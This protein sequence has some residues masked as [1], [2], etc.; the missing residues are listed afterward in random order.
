MHAEALREA[1]SDGRRL[2]AALQRAEQRLEASQALSCRTIQSL[3]DEL[4]QRTAVAAVGGESPAPLA[5]CASDDG[6]G[7]DGDSALISGAGS[8]GGSADPLR[9][10]SGVPAGAS[11]AH[12]TSLQCGG[13]GGSD[14]LP[15]CSDATAV[16]RAGGRPYGA[17]GGLLQPAWEH[18]AAAER[19]ASALTDCSSSGSGSGNA[20]RS[21]ASSERSDDLVRDTAPTA[22]EPAAA[23]AAMAT[24][25]AAAVARPA[26]VSSKQPLL[27]AALSDERASNAGAASEQQHHLS[28]CKP[29]PLA[30]ERSSDADAASEQQLRHEA[31]L[32]NDGQ[33]ECATGPASEQQL[34]REAALDLVLSYKQL[35]Q[36]HTAARRQW[37][38]Q[39]DAAL[40]ERDALAAQLRAARTQ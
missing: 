37:R 20:G 18:A 28:H 5:A 3:R 9:S 4:R 21:F 34:R 6:D 27:P 7:V 26:A 36:Q 24:Q 33:R 25:L 16:S 32:L 23:S 31:T 10:G 13:E 40:A 8:T 17:N 38:A 12:A 30:S 11:S 2:A 19:G 15:S 1:A 22:P 14:G 35:L 29:P 39:L